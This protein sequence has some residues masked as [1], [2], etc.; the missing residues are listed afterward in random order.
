M[1]RIHRNSLQVL[2]SVGV[3]E[4]RWRTLLGRV[5]WMTIAPAFIAVSYL[6]ADQGRYLC[7]ED[8]IVSAALG[9][10]TE[11]RGLISLRA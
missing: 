6:D 10:T 7:G 4:T 3:R 5:R 11:K 9:V 1:V 8:R 2:S